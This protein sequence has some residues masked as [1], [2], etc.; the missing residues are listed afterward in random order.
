[1]LKIV[2]EEREQLERIETSGKSGMEDYDVEMQIKNCEFLEQSMLALNV[3][4]TL[5]H[6]AKISLSGL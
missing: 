2:R 1:M 5:R 3:L 6:K 4:F